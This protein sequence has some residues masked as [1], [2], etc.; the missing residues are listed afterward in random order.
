[1]H[2][3]KIAGLILV[4]GAVASY[5]LNGLVGSDIPAREMLTAGLGLLGGYYSGLY[6]AKR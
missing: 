6:V 3:V 1:M 5:M 2:M 4:V